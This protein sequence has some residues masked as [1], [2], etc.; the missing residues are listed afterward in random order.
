M[1][2]NKQQVSSSVFA[3]TNAY[4]DV[5]KPTFDA[6]YWRQL[7]ESG[8]E[9]QIAPISA[10][11]K[12][13]A[14]EQLRQI[15]RL[16]P[17][18]HTEQVDIS[19]LVPAKEEW[20]FFPK[21][22]K[23]VLTELMQNLVVY[24]QL[25]PALVWKQLNG[26]YMILG[27]H[28]RYQAF[29]ALHEIF[30]GEEG[31]NPELAERFSRMNCYVYDFNELDDVEAR[32]IIIYDNIIR[33]ENTTAVKAQAVINMNR[34]ELASRSNRK[35]SEQR[36]RIMSSIASVMGTSE[37][38]VKRLYRLRTLIPDFW[39]LVDGTGEDKISTQMARV[40]AMLSDDLQQYIFN[41]HLYR[42]KLSAADMKQLAKA[43]SQDDV[44]AVY[45]TPQKYVITGRLEMP[46]QPP[47]NYQTIMFVV[48]DQEA[49]ILKDGILQ[50]LDNPQ[51]SQATRDH[52]RKIFA[53]STEG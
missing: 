43:T 42:N 40:F 15:E 21:Q 34:L 2:N 8:G 53:E 6:D 44:D 31:N 13:K 49:N 19:K 3:P 45:S 39:S 5:S 25:S 50:L 28:T 35:P 10:D 18:Y 26:T 46:Q 32:K 12:K 29:K 27:G 30:T 48:S 1:N 38:S 16:Y 41:N 7:T 47:D 22:D 9:E 11:D 52:V 23:N 17:K 20:N 14:D 36:E 24:G 33:R 51:I 4:D 37:G